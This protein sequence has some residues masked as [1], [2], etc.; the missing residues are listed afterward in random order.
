MIWGPIIND[1]PGHSFGCDNESGGY[2]A[3]RHLLDLGRRNIAYIGRPRAPQ[4]R[5]RGTLCGLC[6]HCTRPASNR[7]TRL[8]VPADNSEK[9]G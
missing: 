4:S 8:R 5:A 6:R 9:L 3:T 7:T 2:Q 1:Q